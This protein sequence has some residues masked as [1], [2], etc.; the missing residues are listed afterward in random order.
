MQSKHNI[1]KVLLAGACIPAGYVD[2]ATA[3][4]TNTDT[5][6]EI[7]ITAT[8]V[9]R[10]V[11]STPTAVSVVSRDNIQ[12]YQP[13]SYAD[14][15]EGIPG[16]SI[17]GGS[18]RI[19]E[20]PNVRG[21][22][23][24]QV[25]IRLDGTRQNFDLAH[26]GRFFVDP[27]LVNRIEVVRG[28]ASALYGSGALGGVIS[29]ETIGAK[30]LLREG[31][32]FGARAKIGYQS[33]GDELL[34]SF[35]V[36]GT[37]GP[38]DILGNFVYR[39]VFNDLEG[40]SGNTI[41]D[42]EDRLLNGLINVG[43]DLGQHS[44]LELIADQYDN[45]GENPT[46]ADSVSSPNTVVDRDTRERNLRVKYRYNN[47]DNAL[48]D[49]T[50]TAYYSEIDVTEARFLGD[51]LDDSDFSSR[52]IDI[53]NTSKFASDD[54][55]LALTYG[56]EW[57]KDKQSG[58][59]NGIDRAQFPDAER[60]FTAL[61]AQAEIE[62]FE[63]ISII[64]GIRYDDFS[65]ETDAG[66]GLDNDAFTPRIAVGYSPNE[67]LYLWGS[68]AEAFRAPSLT[69]LFNDGTHFAVPNGLGPNTLVVNQFVPTPNLL[70]EDA[71]TW[72]FG[73]RVR[74]EDEAEDISFQA[75]AT[76]F[77]SD[78]DN[79][80]NQVVT[81]LDPTRPPQ[82]TPPFGP[83]TFFGT[84]QSR[85]VNANISGFEAEA[86]FETKYITASISG[87]TL[88]G[89]DRTNNTGLGAIPQDSLA[90]ALSGIVP[91]WGVRL[92]ARATIASAQRDVPDGSVEADG[93]ETVDLF[94]T[95]VP[96]ALDGFTVTAGIDNLFDEEYSVH[97][98][99]IE[100]PGRSF[101]ITL[102]H[103]FGN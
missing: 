26:R 47:P 62:L 33:N 11:F 64:P 94:V 41:I 99:V 40:G 36:F 16:V 54:V 24:N 58:T 67:W 19:S 37:T 68:W 12:L 66:E 46:A 53:N 57:F 78:V 9:E 77:T 18:R 42:T 3:A 101:R 21:F 50:A 27:D 6:E 31:E 95:W 45:E 7:T 86:K 83:T 96:K 52:G 34:T 13:L 38:V 22:L 90:F 74:F 56:F 25:V 5:V 85:N 15:F 71:E 61:Y 98:T 14:V 48:L 82:F 72:E 89:D 79:F 65:Q 73:A 49:L 55:S 91:D 44:R 39:Q 80:V 10:P 8:R 70:P 60:T 4:D 29:V 20:E 76:Y 87:F 43:F 59:R 69:E 2:A 92:G 75:S 1:F 97:P 93:Y 100:Q 23:D 17:Q 88:D 81:F 84:T 30:D 28:S 35:G 51:R 63:Q 102:S 32:T 103:R